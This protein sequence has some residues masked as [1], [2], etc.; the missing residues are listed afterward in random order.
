MPEFIHVNSEETLK[1]LN[2]NKQDK[3]VKYYMDG[4]SHCDDLEPIW[5]LVES[6][7]KSNIYDKTL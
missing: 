6:R 7:I 1:K 3:L 2:S 5:K 4:C